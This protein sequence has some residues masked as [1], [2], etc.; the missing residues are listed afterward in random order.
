MSQKLTERQKRFVQHYA[1]DPNALQAAKKA[2]Y[3]SPGVEGHRLLKNA[4]IVTA[5]RSLTGKAEA[6][7]IMSIEDRKKRLSEIANDSDKRTSMIALDL[8]N[9]MEAVYIQKHEVKT[10]FQNKSDDEVI[11]DV[12]RELESRGYKVI[13]PDEGS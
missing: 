4:K 8:L 7:R 6:K 3:K 2:G 1:R 10:N 13:A 5:L 9:K 12:I 11:Q